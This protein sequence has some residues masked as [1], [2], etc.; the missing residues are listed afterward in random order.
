[1]T[2]TTNLLA[3]TLG[4]AARAQRITVADGYHSD[5]GLNVFT[6]RRSFSA[7]DTYPLIAILPAPETSERIVIDGGLYLVTADIDI[8]GIIST[9]EEDLSTNPTALRTD[10]RRAL[11]TG[12]DA[13]ECLLNDIE[14]TG[15]AE[16]VA[17]DDETDA[18]VIVTLRVSWHETPTGA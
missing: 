8:V 17:T 4:L 14:W 16:P 10:L 5:A 13:L 15:S 11:L 3:V 1:M 9:P 18:Q 7:A 12:G 6:G 2:A